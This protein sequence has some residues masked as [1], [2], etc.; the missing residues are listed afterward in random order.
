MLHGIRA[1]QNLVPFQRSIP[2]RYCKVVDS[3]KKVQHIRMHTEILAYP[4]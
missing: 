1:K 2:F 4:L 3:H